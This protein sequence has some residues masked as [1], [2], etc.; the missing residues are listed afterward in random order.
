LVWSVVGIW[1]L[2]DATLREA[3][4]GERG[5]LGKREGQPQPRVR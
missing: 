3:A 2:I 4:W 5:Y 1:L